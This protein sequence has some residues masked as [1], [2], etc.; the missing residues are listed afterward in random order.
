MNIL[1]V[2]N[3]ASMY[4]ANTS[5]VQLIAQL[6]RDDINVYV[7]LPTDGQ[8]TKE[9][10]KLKCKYRIIGEYTAAHESGLI[11]KGQRA[12]NLL[13]NILY[14]KRN[15]KLVS[16]WNID[17]IHTNSA[18]DSIG[19]LLSLY[20]G[21]PHVWHIREMMRDDYC[22]E[23]DFPKLNYYLLKRSNKVIFISK[24]VKNQ[25]K[26]VSLNRNSCVI[27]NGFDLERYIIYKD[28]KKKELTRLILAGFISPQKGQMDAVRA[29][30]YLVNHKI[31]SVRLSIVGDGDK[32]Y[33]Q[34]IKKYIQQ[35]GLDTYIEILPFQN[36]LNTIRRESD[37]ALMCSRKE[38]LGRV[39]I[40]SMA[41]QLLV[42]GT[43]SGGTKELIEDGHTGY[44]YESGD[45]RQ[46]ADKIVTAIND[47]DK[48]QKMI[49]SAQKEVIN[50]FA[51]DKYAT[52]IE[53]IYDEL[54]GKDKYGDRY[55]AKT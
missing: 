8:V 40:E 3:C 4:G 18:I 55:K 25:W 54:M 37:I 2:A 26:S 16:D 5:M 19:G 50:K 34:G 23:Y 7:W 28:L 29:I 9:L 13:N 22:L 48:T 33:V 30:K 42:I 20:T 21:I 46:L 14:I 1:F 43:N 49:L 17:I 41:G 51:V 45:W 52:Q 11:S 12:R 39:T 35:H 32:L 27:H 47:W 6:K 10:R 24:A 53:R 44:L 15:L 36:D 31:K 38:A